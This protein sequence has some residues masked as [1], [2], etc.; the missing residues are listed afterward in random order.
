[1]LCGVCICYGRYQQKYA[2]AKTKTES[3]TTE[4]STSTKAQKAKKEKGQK[5]KL[6]TV[7]F[8]KRLHHTCLR[9]LKHEKAKIKQFKQNLNVLRQ[10]YFEM[11]GPVPKAEEYRDEFFSKRII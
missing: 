8:N 4:A 6:F 1:M 2:K 7:V 11:Y 10:V 5:T 3:S 9:V